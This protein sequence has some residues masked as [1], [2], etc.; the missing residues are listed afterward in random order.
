MGKD[1]NLSHEMAQLK[2]AFNGLANEV[3][4]LKKQLKIGTEVTIKDLAKSSGKHVSTIHYRLFNTP[5]IEPEVD[6][7]K[8]GRG[9][10]IKA[11]C[12]GRLLA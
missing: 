3:S 10:V 8:V 2:E 12:V 11:S 1:I 4:Q 5:G 9:Y 7:H 6:F